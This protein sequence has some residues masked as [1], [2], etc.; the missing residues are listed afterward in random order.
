[1]KDKRSQYPNLGIYLFTFLFFLFSYTSNAQVL[2]KVSGKVVDANTQAPLVGVS[3]QNKTTNS[4]GTSTNSEGEFIIDASIG[5]ILLFSYVGYGDLQLTVEKTVLNVS[6]TEDLAEL[7]E[8]VVIGYGTAKKSDLTGS[9][10]R[11]DA[12]TFKSQPMTQLTDM[13][14]GTVAGF[15]SNQ[16]TSAIGGGSMQVRGPKSLLAASSPMI[17]LD[18]AIYNGS[19]VDINPS[20][21]QSIDILKDASSAAVYGSRAAAGVLMITTKK[22]KTDKPQINFSAQ[23]GAAEVANDFKPFNAAEYL[24]YRRDV[25]RGLSSSSTLPNYY[26]YNPEDLPDGVSLEQWRSASNNPQSDNTLEWLGRLRFFPTEIENYM[27]GKTTDWYGKVMAQALRQDYDVNISGRSDRTSYYWSLGYVDNEGIILGDDF[28]AIRTRLNVDFKVADWLNMGVNSQFSDRDESAVPANLGGMF[29]TSPYGSEFEPDGSIKWYPGDYT[30]GQNPLINYYGQDRLRKVNALFANLYAKVNLPF[31][32]N[33]ELS[34]QPRYDFVKDYNFWS[35]R[36]IVG[37][38]QYSGGYGSRSESTSYGWIVDNILK[39]NNSFGDHDF[40]LTLL[41]S[42]EQNR[43]WGSSMSNE[44]FAPNENLGFYGLEFGNNPSIGT[45][46]SQIRGD[47]LMARLNYTL[48]DKYLFTASVRRDG[49]SAF[50]KKNPRAVFPA[51]AFA[52]KLSDE[53]FFNMD[54]IDHMKLRLSWGVNGNRDVGAYAALAQIG[55][56]LYYDGN[57]VQV[58]VYNNSLANYDLRWERTESLNFGLD[59]GIINNRVNASVDYYDMTTTDLLMNRRLPELTG[60]TSVTSNLGELGNKGFELSLNTLNVDKPNFS[61]RTNFAFSL[62]RNKIKSLFGDFKDVE[63]DGKMVRQELP[64]YT[65]EWF[66]GQPINRIWNYDVVGVWQVDEA[67]EAARYRMQPGDFK[68]RDVNDDGVFQALDD[69]VF[70][71]YTEPRHRLGLRNEFSF[72]KNF[73]ASLFIRADLG[74]MGVFSQALHEPSTYDRRNNYGFPY[75]T[76]ENPINDFAR[77]NQNH[78]AYGGGI[79]IYK[80]RSFVRIQDFSLSY[81]LPDLLS[82]KMKLNNVRV[83][84]A[85]RNIYTFD[86]WPGWD[87]E[88]AT[89]PMPKSYTLGLNV[90]L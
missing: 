46:G 22:G 56:N 14:N 15:N 40:D 6:M 64:D 68:A 52:W 34:F 4:A 67:E 84:T 44:S 65:N 27:A 31:G 85:L 36:T 21:I 69:K 16:S 3:I 61:W 5:N 42:A 24:Q 89:S 66:P 8:V 1:M 47:A 81:N 33:Y 26:Y 78:T 72:L 58:G 30:G 10:A 50:G 2:Q 48:L 38:S 9:V 23:L 28:K 53:K 18:G 35:S 17:V 19:L 86:K 82:K 63:V 76:P 77:L 43:V 41:H 73:S 25:L 37:G 90:S 87:P 62:N 70:I 51:A 80:S 39:W 7:D 54:W 45:S 11:I 74:F 75:W 83:F 29:L 57:N 88:S 79:R 32:F 59:F 55:S 12:E 13:L 60:F 49:F 20:D 71:G